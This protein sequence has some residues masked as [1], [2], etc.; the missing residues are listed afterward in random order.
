[1]NYQPSDSIVS[2][3]EAT[4]Q[5]REAICSAKNLQNL[6]IRGELLG[7]K[8]HS[9]G[10]VYFTLLGKETRISCVIF[11]SNASS[12]ISWPKD[13]D[14]VLVRGRVDVY[15]ARGTYQIYATTLLPLGAGAKARAKEMLKNKL[16][17]EGLFDI[18]NKRALPQFPQK[19]AIITSPT[20]AAV[21]DVIKIASLRYGASRLIVIPSLMQGLDA[22]GEILDAF[23]LSRRLEGLDVVM[24][25]RGGGSRDDLDVFDDERVVRAVRSSPVPVIT[26]LG[27]QIDSTL[28]DLAADAA[29]PTPSGAAER[30]FPD[31]A[32]IL[33]T[34]QNTGRRM[35][36]LI[37]SRIERLLGITGSF[38]ERFIFNIQRTVVLPASEYIKNISVKLSD[39]I[40]QRVRRSENSLQ[41][42]A[43]SLN[44]VSP[45]NI[46]SKGYAIC[47]GADG[48]MLRDASALTA[49]DSVSVTL[50]DG[51]FSAV[52]K[53]TVTQKITD[54]RGARNAS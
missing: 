32:D 39:L 29:S 9:S 47:R 21:Q 7:F 18:R 52:V 22:P 3:D 17:A 35:E 2:V 31:C 38:R 40:V 8:R 30:V 45:L 43:A 23:N 12:I 14:E 54:I 46:L 25:V 37:V 16:N 19:V 20:G 11:R 10:H 33:F 51:W 4:G 27:H 49:G 5:L 50:R 53:E 13:G 28:S 1:M 34:L 48:L 44:A 41:T 36:L 26:G 6:S 24:L 15:G 42:S